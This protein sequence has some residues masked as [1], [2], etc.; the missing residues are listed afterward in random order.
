[1]KRLVEQRRVVP[2]GAHIQG[3]VSDHD[4]LGSGVDVLAE[5]H[6]HGVERAGD[7]GLEGADHLRRMPVVR[8]AEDSRRAWG[9]PPSPMATVT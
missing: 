2:H 9:S 6:D 3:R 4:V 5:A 8:A 1:V 7:E